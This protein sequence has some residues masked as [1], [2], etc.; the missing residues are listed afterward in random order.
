MGFNINPPSNKPIIRE[1]ANMQ[2]D[3]GAGNLGYFES[4]ERE[5]KQESIFIPESEGD[6]FKKEGDIEFHDE[7]FSFSKFIANIIFSLK[8]W[9]KKI[10][11]L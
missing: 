3:G 10:F 11:N 1:A 2:N 5:K 9:I 7:P 4:G 8:E 6:T